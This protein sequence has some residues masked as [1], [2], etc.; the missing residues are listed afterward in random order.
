LGTAIDFGSIDETFALTSEGVWLKKHAREYGFSLS[1]PQG[2]EGTTGYMWECWHY[3][4][5]TPAG[6]EMESEFFNGIQE[7]LLR[8]FHDKR[9]ALSAARTN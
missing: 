5:I 3:R 8:F 1:Y 4:Y 7:Y 6:T 2:M 9:N